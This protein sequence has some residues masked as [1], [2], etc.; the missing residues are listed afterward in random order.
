M[1]VDDYAWDDMSDE[2]RRWWETPV[3][4][5]RGGS[6][7]GATPD[8]RLAEVLATLGEQGRYPIFL[9]VCDHCQH[10]TVLHDIGAD[11]GPGRLGSVIGHHCGSCCDRSP[12]DDRKRVAY[13]IPGRATDKPPM[14]A[15]ISIVRA[16]AP[17]STP[18]TSAAHCLACR[19]GVK[20]YS[21]HGCICGHTLAVHA[22]MSCSACKRHGET[23]ARFTPAT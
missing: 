16:Q 14:K 3:S 11:M 12:C 15:F 19:G 23:C 13:Q 20:C 5:V 8:E 7:V 22:F 10:E 2:A 1:P 9:G 17:L 4:P 6:R 18:W 21:D